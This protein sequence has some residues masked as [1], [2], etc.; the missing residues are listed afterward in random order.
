MDRVAVIGGGA[1]GTAIAAVLTRKG[2]DV[3]LWAYEQS[4]VETIN[5]THE[6]ADYLP[7]VDI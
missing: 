6:N 7:D 2:Y 1:W 5:S 3:R 4:L